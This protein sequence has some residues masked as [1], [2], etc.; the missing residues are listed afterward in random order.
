MPTLTTN[1]FAFECLPNLLPVKR[2][3][4]TDS[5]A[6]AQEVSIRTFLSFLP[7]S[8]FAVGAVAVHS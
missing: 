3:V 2:G 7:I 8:A 5:K 4:S 1:V 6:E